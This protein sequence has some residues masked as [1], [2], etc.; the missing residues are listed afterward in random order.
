MNHNGGFPPIYEGG[1][2]ET[3]QREFSAQNV[4]SLS[5]IL[6]NNKTNKLLIRREEPIIFNIVD[7]KPNFKKNKN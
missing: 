5:Q 1:K 6:N 2:K 4:L 7:N 3:I